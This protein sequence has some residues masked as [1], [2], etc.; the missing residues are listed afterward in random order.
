MIIDIKQLKEIKNPK[1]FVVEGVNGAGKGTIIEKL[2][3]Y[4]AD[5]NID[6]LFTREPGAGDFGTAIRD[7]VLNPKEKL[8]EV[9]ELFLFSADRSN[10]VAK[11]I[12][13]VIDKKT[14]V[15]S[16][17]YYYSTISFQGYG[18]GI[19]LDQI[20]SIC[21]IAIQGL[22]P[23]L[24]LLL[25]VDAEIGLARTKKIREQ[26]RDAFEEE[27]INFHK[28]IRKGYLELAK[29]LP[30]KFIIIDTNKNPDEVWEEVKSIF[31]ILFK[32]E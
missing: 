18:R 16:D 9:T 28:K 5:K 11:I 1:F 4:F 27:K 8:A 13:P 32:N 6:T 3:L 24:V 21:N 19:N 30:E 31:D 29:N 14:T 20:H 23:D 12:K 26:G 15:I 17:R 7:L 25:D 22:R 2:K 10:H